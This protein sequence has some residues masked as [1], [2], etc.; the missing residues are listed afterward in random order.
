[1]DARRI[2]LFRRWRPA[3]LWLSA[4]CRTVQWRK[5]ELATSPK[6]ERGSTGSPPYRLMKDYGAP[7]T[8]TAIKSQRV[9]SPCEPSDS[10]GEQKRNHFDFLLGRF[11]QQKIFALRARLPFGVIRDAADALVRAGLL[12]DFERSKLRYCFQDAQQFDEMIVRINATV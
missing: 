9:Q 5:P 12:D 6:R 8:G 3:R 7:S 2:A 4:Q 11:A 10:T 1:M